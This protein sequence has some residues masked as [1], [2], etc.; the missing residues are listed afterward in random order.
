MPNAKTEIFAG[1]FCQKF[2]VRSA[3]NTLNG[4][5]QRGQEDNKTWCVCTWFYYV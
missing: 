2:I 4:Q 3:S 1:C 5:Y